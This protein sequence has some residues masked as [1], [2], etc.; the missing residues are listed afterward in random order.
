M[1]SELFQKAL[2]GIQA[3][4]GLTL[5]ADRVT[6]AGMS[7]DAVRIQGAPDGIAFGVSL[8]AMPA[9]AVALF[10]A[11]AFAGPLIRNVGAVVMRDPLSWR[12]IVEDGKTN[13]G[14]R[15]T[16]LVNGSDVSNLDS[17]EFEVWESLEIECSARVPRI[18]GD[19]LKQ[20][21][22]VGSQCLALIM[23]C[24]E[25]GLDQDPGAIGLPEGA[26]SLVEVNRYER[27]PVNRTMCIRHYGP[28]CWV[29]DLDFA[30]AYGS[31]G[32][33]FVEVHHRIPVSQIGAGYVVDPLRDLVP[34]CSNCHSMVHRRNPPYSPQE[35]R[36]LIGGS[37]DKHILSGNESSLVETISRSC[38]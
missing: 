26:K 36:A 13:H 32:K 21:I 25:T 10:V 12:R 8:S 6:W 34:L 19:G 1:E 18:N 5:E 31:I 29:C 33:D 30:Q 37:Q 28:T 38:S 7:A 14:I 17:I 2:V 9:R 27:S 22:E 24:Q 35:L 4:T 11:D 20:L 3:A 23:E 16:I 15:T